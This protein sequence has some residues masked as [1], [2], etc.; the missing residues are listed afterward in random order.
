MNKK[1]N[2]L[3][4]GDKVKIISGKYK[5]KEGKIIKIIAKKNQIFI[6]NINLKIKHM[7][8]KQANDKGE[9]KQIEGCIH[10]SNLKKV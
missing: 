10:K 1:N 7:K 2:I 9:I 6:E 3:K 8:S 4:V 5:D